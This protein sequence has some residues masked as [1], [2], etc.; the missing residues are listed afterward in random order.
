[1][2]ALTRLQSPLIKPLTVLDEVGWPSILSWGNWGMAHL[3]ELPKSTEKGSSRAR[4]LKPDHLISSSWLSNLCYLSFLTW[5]PILYNYHFFPLIECTALRMERL[6]HN[7]V[8]VVQLFA[9]SLSSSPEA[10][11]QSVQ[12]NEF[13]VIENDTML[14]ISSSSA[15][16]CEP[17]NY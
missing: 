1:M 2:P 12:T 13:K 7:E 5:A 6:M 14:S 11:Q 15:V 10:P 9:L 4:K 3:N 17:N 8:L 16:L